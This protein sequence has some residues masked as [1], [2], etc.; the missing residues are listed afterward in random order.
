VG[1]SFCTVFESEA[2]PYGTL[3]SYHRVL[4]DMRGRIDRLAADR[5][6]TPLGDFESYAPEDTDGL[7]DEEMQAEMPPAEWFAPAAGLAAVNA[8]WDHLDA[9]PGTFR[10]QAALMEELSD[11]GDELEAARRAG[12]RFRFAVVM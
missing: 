6:L 8:L 1:A 10:R 2:P 4:L 7:L 11:L 9:H 3:G 5:G 12:T